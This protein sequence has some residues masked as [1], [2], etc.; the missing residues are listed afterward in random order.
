M[1]RTKLLEDNLQ[2][3]KGNGCI[4]RSKI[5]VILDKEPGD[6]QLD[7]SAN[8]HTMNILGHV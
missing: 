8:E 6:G 4:V 5:G 1:R 7:L 3:E 2:A